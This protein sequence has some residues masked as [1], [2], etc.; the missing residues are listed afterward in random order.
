MRNQVLLI[1]FLILVTGTST[2]LLSRKAD[3]SLGA[4]ALETERGREEA[5]LSKA[6][7]AAYAAQWRFD[8]LK[9]ERDSSNNT[10]YAGGVGGGLWKSLDGAVTWNRV[11]TWNQW[12]AVSCIAQAP[13]P[14]YT[15]YV[16]TGEGLSQPSGTSYNSGAYG[17]GIFKLNA[18]D[19]PSLITPTVFNG[20]LYNPQ[21]GT[22][23]WYLVNKIAVNPTNPN[24]ILAGT[25]WGLYISNDAGATWA[26]NALSG[27]STSYKTELVDDLKWSYDGKN[28]FVAVG[29]NVGTNALLYSNNGGSTWAAENSTTNT[30]YPVGSVG[31]IAL[32]VAP[33]DSKVVY[34]VMATTSAC[35]KGVYKSTDAGHTWTP[36]AV[37][38]PLFQLFEEG[39]GAGCQGW[40]DNVIAVNSGNSDHIYMGG[41]NF[42]TG[43]AASGVKP[44][45][46]GY[47]NESNPYYMHPDKHAIVVA[48]NNPDL[49]FVGCDGGIFK[50]IDAESDF[51]NPTY[52]S[53][54]RGYNVTQN[55]GIG[56]GIDGSVIGGAQDNG[57]NYINYYGNSFGA[58]QQVIGGDGIGNAVSQIDPDFYFGG[59]Y[60]AALVRS[61]DHAATFGGVFDV[62]IDPS[63][64]G[65]ATVCGA[66]NVSGDAQ[67]ITPYYLGETK[68]ALNGMRKVPFVASDRKYY[69]GEVVSL[70]SETDKYQFNVTLSDS[71]PLDS[72]VYVDDPIRSRL[73]LATACG[74]YLTSDALDKAIIPRWFKLTTSINGQA[75][76]FVT[77]AD[78]NNLYVGTTSGYVYHFSKLN[79][80]ADTCVY[81]AGALV[82]TLY[83]AGSSDISVANVATGGRSI[84]GIDVDPTDNNHIV[85]VVAGFSSS[86]TVSHV[87]ESHDGGATWTGLP[88]GA[89]GGLPNMPVYS[90]VVHDAHTVIIG[91]EFGIWSWNGTAWHEEN[92]N[93]ERVPVYRLI[94]RTL[95][96]DGCPVLYLGSHGRGMWRCT[97]LTP[98][99]C[100]TAVGTAV[101]NIKPNAISGINI[102]PNPVANAAKISL[103]IDNSASVTLR[104][105]D[106]SGRLHSEKTYRD[107]PGGPNTFD[108]DASELSNGT[109]VLA[110]TVADTRSL[111]RLFVVTK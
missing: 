79:M 42:Y 50:S 95:Y 45:D 91:T 54:N 29:S 30:G 43:S 51:P 94:E 24:Q 77:T 88:T 36:V 66:Q 83:P 70:T 12:T 3:S 55:Y 23:P 9:D 105:F 58:S 109:Y 74:V 68:N 98:S 86:A 100:Q 32:A 93:F 38:G 87:Y 26:L 11:T 71:V 63:G 62:K 44:A 97:T 84:E 13:A 65:G 92:G 47:S 40:Y 108:L 21:S 19:S 14:D 20:I 61:A 22:S 111:S 4:F 60:F 5:H 57:T 48:D 96:Q 8:R 78:G 35:T 85:A 67:F 59:V 18:V 34:G 81:P 15:I 7:T 75:E 52:T 72:T 46:Y 90:V 69:A 106:M 1:S 2:L 49:M 99:G 27:V 103:N 16:G 110:A 102:Y 53:R 101:N 80:H 33:S 76:S 17:N 31:R 104:V 56:A 89:T 10:L 37:G 28:V 6:Q 25:G 107:V 39:G 82:G 64:Q 41:V 73:F